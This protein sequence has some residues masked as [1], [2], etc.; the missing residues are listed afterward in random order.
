MHMP[1]RFS[2]IWQPSA[3]STL[4]LLLAAGCGGGSGTA[5]DSGSSGQAAS[6]DDVPVLQ[7][8][9]PGVSPFIAYVDLDVPDLDE[10]E[11]AGFRIEPQP[12][13]V[14][15]AIAVEYARSYLKRRGLN[16][17]ERR[18]SIPIFGLYAGQA[19]E[20]D[21]HLDRSDG[22]TESL[23][24]R[25][26]AQPY[27]D[28]NGVYDRLTM[29]KARTPGDGLGFDFI[30]LKSILGS[31]VLLDSD[32][33]VRWV[34]PGVPIALSST[35]HKGGFIVGG[36]TSSA[37]QRVEMDGH[38]ENLQL[39]VAGITN[40]HHDIVPGKQGLLMMVDA[41]R[42]GTAILESILM[43]VEPTDGSV[44]RQWD[45]GESISRRMQSQ[46][47]D[48]AAFV[49]YGIDWFH[50]NSALYDARDNSLLVSGR[51]DFVAKIDY[52]SGDLLWVLGDP[53]KYWHGFPS[54]AALNLDLAPGG[55]WPVGQHALSLTPD[56]KLMLFN[57]GQA[58]A[59]QPAREPVG[60]QRS[61]SAVSV[62]ALDEP[63]RRAT[64][65]DRFVHPDS[66]FS[67]FCSSATQTSPG[68][69][70][71]VDYANAAGGT[72]LRLVGVKEDG[73]VGLDMAFPNAGCNG[74][75]NAQPIALN[76]LRIE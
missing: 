63:A 49:R 54:L 18:L 34:V 11:E 1:T 35:F 33:N 30:F 39:N 17:G 42:N 55:L 31:P 7:A 32:G 66:I 73:S 37:F 4:V 74:A 60:E 16:D 53:T 15:Q 45:L 5:P 9:R 71:L 25:I 24:T 27:V 47:E 68:G 40:F 3:A 48:P 56:G 10:V 2:R 64:E 58:S 43:E 69:A 36:G 12:G 28:T 26:E 61:F 50:M 41:T 20:V 14:S 13:T 21:I 51:E 52:D 72:S 57:N 22:S 46:G 65:V 70:M 23:R 8:V 67:A 29:L 44:L 76:D 59:N 19:N 6:S 75:W 62:Y 38:I